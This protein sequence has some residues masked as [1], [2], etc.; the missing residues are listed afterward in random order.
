MLIAMVSQWSS[1]CPIVVVDARTR[2]IFSSS[3]YDRVHQAEYSKQAIDADEL[4]DD[5]R[6]W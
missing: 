3:I 1:S 4:G 5:Q 2:V 6:C